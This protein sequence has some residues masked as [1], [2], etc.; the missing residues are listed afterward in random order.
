MTNE[1][2]SATVRFH[3]I[4]RQ[5]LIVLVALALFFCLL[6]VGLRAYEWHLSVDN[7]HW[8][9]RLSN[10]FSVNREGNIPT[11]FNASLLFGAFLITAIIARH[12]VTHQLEWRGYWS[13][14]ALLFLYLT[15]DEAGE[16]HEVF[17]VPLQEMLEA[18]GYL[19]F[20][21]IVVGIV[22]ALVI[23]I[24]FLPFVL[25]LPRRT[26][27]LFF[28]AGGIYVGGAVGIEAI[29]ANIWYENDGPTLTFSAVGAVEEFFEM[30]GVSIMIYAL[31][32]YL[33]EHV[34]RVELTIESPQ[35]EAI[36]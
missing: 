27:M 30:T 31:L 17:T 13:S 16:I 15:L 26:M 14:L 9:Y 34:N 4:P 6:S 2:Q 24:L 32:K 35:I 5:V 21:W 23:G 20:A 22:F 12:K 10:I 3:I 11:W 8:V 29:S 18:D 25:A 36:E 28:L 1:S 19:Y 33:S 7:T